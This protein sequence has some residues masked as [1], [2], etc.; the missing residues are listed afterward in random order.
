MM[1][2]RVPTALDLP[3]VRA[4]RTR[5][6]ELDRSARPGGV[7]DITRG[8]PPVPRADL[9]SADGSVEDVVPTT[10]SEAL[11]RAL[12]VAIAVVALVCLA[13]VM[14]LV[15]LAIRLSS[16][17]P[18]FYSQV[19]VGVDRRSRWQTTHDQRVYDL[20]GKPFTM[21]KFRTM[22]VDAEKEGQAVWAAPA[23]PRATAVGRVLRKTRLDE[24]PQLYNVLRGDM[25][26]VGPR[27]ER[28]TIFADLRAHI[29]AYPMRQRVKPGITGWAQ[30]NQAYDACVDDVRRKV[31][32]DLEYVRRQ[33]LVEDLRIMTMT[34]PVMLFRKGGW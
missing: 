2:E 28:P 4:R 23:D 21:H 5:G 11:C 19:R 33:G 12:N 8:L 29:P 9:G 18:V 1:H 32:Y 16:K 30:I 17:G 15:A 24:L 14:L 34:L 3:S 20:G 6:G 25:N 31:E 22:V 26:I 13:P 10:R 7:L 27:P